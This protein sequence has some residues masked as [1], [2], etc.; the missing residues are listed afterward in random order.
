MSQIH[1]QFE[2]CLARLQ[3]HLREERYS[4][5]AVQNYS[6][7]VRCFLRDLEKRGRTVESVSAADVSSYIDALHLKRRRGRFPDHSRRMHRAAIHMLLR[8]VHGQ[9][10]PVLAPATELEFAQ[11]EVIAAYEAWMTDVRGLAVE[12]RRHLRSEAQRLLEWLGERGSGA[13]LVALSVAELDVYVST[14]GV[15]MR[16]RSIA[17]MVSS[18]RSFLRYLHE[19]DRVRINLADSLCGPKIYE[20]EDIPSTLLSEDVEQALQALRQDRSPLGLRDYAIVMLLVT[21]GLRAGEVT[22][23]RLSDIDWHHERLRIRQ[24]K[25]G[26]DLELP[27]LRGPAD[28]LLDYLRQARPKTTVREVFLRACAPYRALSGA[29]SLRHIITRRLAAIGVYPT[30]KHGAHALRHARAISMLRSGVSLKVIGDVLGHRSARSTAIYLKLATDD[31][32]SV[33]LDLPG[34]VWP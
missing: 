16:R 33:A 24:S 28:A 7:A 32:R 26:A 1:P 2:T 10:P 22:A 18:L 27:L 25:T 34:R 5:G 12:T 4:P 6:Y 11:R 29:A 8:L 19:T 21:Y 14:R 9:W 23:L 15:S 13:A 31:L 3:E 20:L 30:G 17:G